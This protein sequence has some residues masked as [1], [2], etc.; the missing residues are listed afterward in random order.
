MLADHIEAMQRVC[1]DAEPS[2]TD[3]ATL[4]SKERWLVY[5]DLVRHRLRHVVGVALSRTKATLGS[6]AFDAHVDQWLASGGPATR[7]FRH[8]PRDFHAGMI[9]HWRESHPPWLSALAEY[10][11]TRWD[12]RYAP[13]I[14]ADVEEFAFDRIPVLNPALTVLRLDYPVHHAPTPEDGYLEEETVLCVYRNRDHKPVS[15]LLNPLAASL[16][17][18]WGR[19]DASVTETVHQVAR[20]HGTEI[21]PA[22]V[23]KLSAMIADFLTRGILLGAV[24]PSG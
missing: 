19:G 4:G 3:L 23:E 6:S 7:Y 21:G 12:V 14:R 5:R 11:I 10:E 9:Q 18:A 17:E 20:A 13:S 2:E 8:V 15:W 24:D 16:V 22:F 1:F